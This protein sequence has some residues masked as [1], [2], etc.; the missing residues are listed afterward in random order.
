MLTFTIIY[1][2]TAQG[3]FKNPCGIAV[4]NIRERVAVAD[5]NNSRVQIFD[6]SG[7]FLFELGT[8]H[9][10]VTCYVYPTFIATS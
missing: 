6:F 9:N 4:D 7:K 2:G 8:Y 1:S 10:L 5:F 3:E